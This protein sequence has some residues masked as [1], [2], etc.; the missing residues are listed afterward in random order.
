MAQFGS[1]RLFLAITG[2]IFS[3]SAT[4]QAQ[5]YN[6]K[7][8]QEAQM[9]DLIGSIKPG[10]VLILGEMHGLQTIRDQQLEILN[11][12]RATG[13]KVSVGMEFFNYTDQN[14]INDYRSGAMDEAAF[15]KAISWGGYDF[16]LYRDQL[17][18]GELGMGVNLTRDV[19]KVISKQ[20]L[21]AL[22][23]EQ[24]K[25]LPPNF[26]IGR[27][28]Y[29]QRFFLAMGHPVP[30][31]SLENY[32]LAQSAWDDTM[33]WQT[34][35]FQKQHPDQVFVIIVGEFHVQ[36]GGGLPN[37]IQARLQQ[38]NLPEN[39]VTVSQVYT[40]G[41]T[42]QDIQDSL[43]PSAEDGPRADYIFLSK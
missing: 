27:D 2:L 13:L 20:G 30:V 8:L 5:I 3:F 23:P 36:H 40:D 15:L 11:A 26:T 21:A 31:A 35:E 39:I 37:R 7:T 38:E 17:L 25:L 9:S 19:T 41:M 18:F 1:V 14:L 12:V 28:S 32:F 29:R 34:V 43:Q 6:G 22:T 4:A 33:A 24:N 10:T 16:G 42:E